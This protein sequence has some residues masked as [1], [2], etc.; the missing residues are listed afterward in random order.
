MSMVMSV[1]FESEAVNDEL[2]DNGE[3]GDGYNIPRHLQQLEEIT[4]TLRLPSLFG[5]V[6]DLNT[7]DDTAEP[8]WFLAADGLTCVR[9]LIDY[10]DG[11]G[12]S[13]RGRLANDSLPG[14][15][16]RGQWS[17]EQHAEIGSLVARAVAADLRMFEDQLMLAEL[18][19]TR[20]CFLL[21]Y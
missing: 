3:A 18:R 11:I 16:F 17:A 12:F 2:W 21:S 4:R 20:F 13:E 8:E 6:V 19:G 5:F 15:L 1:V 10:L 7:V 9:G 14:R